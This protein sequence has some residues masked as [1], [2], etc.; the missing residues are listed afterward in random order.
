MVL[1]NRTKF[2]F[3]TLLYISL[4]LFIVSTNPNNLNLALL[5]LPFTL[6]FLIIYITSQKL[7]SI[8]TH[9]SNKQIRT[10]SIVL[11]LILTMM[12]VLQSLHQLTVRDFLLSTTTALLLSWYFLRINR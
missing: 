6:L 7:I 1:K 5:I 2:M 11:S 8:T 9:Y 12:A 10:S 4:P 3:I